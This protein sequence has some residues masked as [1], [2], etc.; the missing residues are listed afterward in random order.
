MTLSD[1]KFVLFFFSLVKK[2]TSPGIQEICQF[3]RERRADEFTRNAQ[4]LVLFQSEMRS[5]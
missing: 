4:R 3:G 2:E 1:F 5:L